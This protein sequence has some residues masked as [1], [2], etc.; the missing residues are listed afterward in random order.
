M[1]SLKAMSD[2]DRVQS[3]SGS[4]ER[5]LKR[6]KEKYELNTRTDPTKLYKPNAVPLPVR[7]SR[8]SQI[9]MEE[10][11]TVFERSPLF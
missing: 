1:G 11:D 10:S 8:A 3:K 2:T 5:V 6:N 7:A 4:K 9:Y